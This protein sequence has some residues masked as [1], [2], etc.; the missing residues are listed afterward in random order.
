LFDC[1]H[2]SI[3]K[4]FALSSSL[5]RSLTASS[6]VTFMTKRPIIGSVAAFVTGDAAS[7]AP[8]VVAPLVG[9]DVLSFSFS[10]V[11]AGRLTFV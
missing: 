10:L 2:F 4:I 5:N 9:V 8:L 1:P 7:A 3:F 6:D 11:D